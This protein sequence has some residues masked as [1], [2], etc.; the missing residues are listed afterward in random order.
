M[1][2]IDRVK[3]ILMSPQAEWPTIAAEPATTQSIYTGYVMI[4]AAIGPVAILLR[5][6]A[7]GLFA[8]VAIAIASYLIAL[9]ITFLLALIVDALA[10]SFGGTKDFVA[11]LKLV[12]YSYTAAWVAGIFQ[13][14]PV[15]GGIVGLLAAIYAFY[16]FYLGAPVLARCASEK[17]VGF[18]IVIV[19]CGLVLG[20]L[21]MGLLFSAMFGASLAGTGGLGTIR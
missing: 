8:A 20:F 11:S 19:I 16:T 1:N 18:T 7:G 4:L 17:A 6:L 21:L 5:G 15:I 13:L 12:A 10:P 14:L 3:N 2:L 9:A